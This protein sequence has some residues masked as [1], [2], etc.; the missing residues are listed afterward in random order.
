MASN[1][2][3]LIDNLAR[4]ASVPSRISKPV[5]K[6]LTVLLRGQF[7]QGKDSYGTPWVPLKPSTVRAKGGDARILIRG[8]DMRDETRAV[9]M[10]GAGISLI[11]VSYTAYHQGPS[12]NRPARPVLPNGTELPESWQT[13]IAKH[14]SQAFKKAMNG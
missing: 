9:A 11:S 13:V 4:L 14:W 8:G 10:S 2:R 1:W 5:A 12:G 7:K 3:R 6:E